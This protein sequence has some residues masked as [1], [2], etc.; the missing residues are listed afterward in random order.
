VRIFAGYTPDNVI[1][2]IMHC[3]AP[4][5]GYAVDTGLS[6]IEVGPEVG[7]GTHYIAEGV[8]LEKQLMP[9]V[10]TNT[11]LVADG[12]QKAVISG[13][14][15]GVQVEWPDGQTD[16]VTDGEVLFAVDL[17]GTYTLKFTAT[18]YLDQEVTIEAFAET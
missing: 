8:A 2:N 10:I 15:E 9:L 4:G 1:R 17:V 7:I 16:V 3:Q 14:P 18:R 13:I 11:P 6:T 5:A 12:L